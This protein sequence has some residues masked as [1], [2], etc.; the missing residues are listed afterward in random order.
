ML[1]LLCTKVETSSLATLSSRKRLL[2]CMES[3]LLG[4][5]VA[6]ILSK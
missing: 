3:D 6:Y 1:L 4:D 5:C 2:A